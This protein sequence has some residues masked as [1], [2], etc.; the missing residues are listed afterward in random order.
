M[1]NIV[2]NSIYFSY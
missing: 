1:N 2:D